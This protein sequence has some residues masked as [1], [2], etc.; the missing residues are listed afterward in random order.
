[1]SAFFALSDF[2]QMMWQRSCITGN[3]TPRHHH[4]QLLLIA[5]VIDSPCL[6]TFFL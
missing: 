1:M 3:H 5:V 6:R 2:S 4:N